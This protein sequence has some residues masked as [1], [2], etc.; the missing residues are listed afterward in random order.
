[1]APAHMVQGSSVTQRSHPSSRSSPRTV[2][3]ACR[4]H[5]AVALG[6][7][8]GRLAGRCFRIAHMGWIN[9]PMVLGALG[10]VEATLVRLGIAHGA[11]G[12]Q[13]AVERL[14]RD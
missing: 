5:Y 4:E 14:S 11:G 9:E 6:G 12:V 10:C 3:A 13:A 1:M 8:L 2:I 7:G